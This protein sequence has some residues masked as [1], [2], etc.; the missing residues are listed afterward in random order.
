MS[1]KNN[2]QKQMSEEEKIKAIIK[3]NKEKLKEIKSKGTWSHMYKSIRVKTLELEKN[4]E[5]SGK[6]KVDNMVEFVSKYVEQNL[7]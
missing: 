3:A 4:K 7:Q 1:E 6:E 5:M 2:E